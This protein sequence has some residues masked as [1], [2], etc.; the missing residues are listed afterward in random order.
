[1]TQ[2]LLLTPQVG[3]SENSA[4]IL[5]SL[6]LLTHQIRVAA[7]EPESLLNSDA[8]SCCWT[9]VPTWSGG[10]ATSAGR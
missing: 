10:C 1:M 8:R 2:V 5:P 3:G 4:D 9:G 6:G 7:L